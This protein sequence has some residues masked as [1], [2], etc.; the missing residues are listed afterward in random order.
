MGGD[1]RGRWEYEWW[2][3]LGEYEWW[4]HLG[5]Y[6]WWEHLGEY[7]WWEHLGEY[8]WWVNEWRFHL[9]GEHEWWEHLGRPDQPRGG[10]GCYGSD[11]YHRRECL[12]GGCYKPCLQ[13][14]RLRPERDDFPLSGELDPDRG[15]RSGL[16]FVLVAGRFG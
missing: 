14:G 16:P 15:Y 5:E 1:S 11:L 2:E 12:L 10:A 6:K 3:H 8:E 7:E 13:R 9:R 4:E